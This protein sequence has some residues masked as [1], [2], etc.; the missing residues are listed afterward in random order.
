MGCVDGAVDVA[1]VE[2]V[3]DSRE[4]LLEAI[5]G[6]PDPNVEAVVTHR[7]YKVLCVDAEFLEYVSSVAREGL[8][9]RGIAH[10][11][12]DHGDHPEEAEEVL[13]ETVVLVERLR[14]EDDFQHPRWFVMQT[15]EVERLNRIWILALGYLFRW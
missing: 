3:F 11:I 2:T 8:S 13:K 6:R 14:G 15:K 4:C 1:V 9:C 5:P 12:L 7:E 10:E